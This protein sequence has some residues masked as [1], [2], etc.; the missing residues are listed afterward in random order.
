MEKKRDQNHKVD[1]YM[2]QNM[3]FRKLTLKLE[4]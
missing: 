4:N 1:R 2:I 3:K